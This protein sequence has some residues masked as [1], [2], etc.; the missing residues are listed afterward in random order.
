MTA[1]EIADHMVATFNAITD[2]RIIFKATKPEDVNE[3]DAERSDFGVYVVAQDE[4]EEPIN[5]DGTTSRRVRVVRV[6]ANGPIN[7]QHTR[8]K[9]L[10]A[11]EQ[12]RESLEGT[13]FDRYR[14]TGNEVLS[15]WDYDALRYRNRFMALFEATYDN[16]S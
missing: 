15:L 6:A 14:W 3:V 16:F 13:D 8:S 11:M 9:Y 7:V 2:K 1:D 4:R 10:K 12:I 5:Q